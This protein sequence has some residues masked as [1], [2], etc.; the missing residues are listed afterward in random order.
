MNILQVSTAIDMADADAAGA[1]PVLELL[2]KGGYMM[3]PLVLLSIVALYIFVERIMTINREAKTP[4]GFTDS[5]RNKVIDGDIN[6]AMDS[7]IDCGFDG[8]QSLQ[9]S[10]GMDIQ[11]IGEKYPDVILMGNLDLDYLMPF[12]KEDEVSKA[13]NELVQSMSGRGKFILSTCNILT[14]AI[15]VDNVLAMYGMV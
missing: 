8:I 1:I 2:T 10:A 14:N 3:L 11:A 6:G 15:P 12:G 4:P 9:P 7:L 5:I 13:S